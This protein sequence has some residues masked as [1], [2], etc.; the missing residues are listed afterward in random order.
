MLHYTQPLHCS[1]EAPGD[2]SHQAGQLLSRPVSLHTHA[3][4]TLLSIDM[5]TRAS[6][7]QVLARRI[8]SLLL[9]FEMMTRASRDQVLAR[10]I[11]ITLH[12]GYN[13]SQGHI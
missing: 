13:Q 4:I 5:T 9:S 7:D 1:I 2:G 8:P 3:A 12:A 10:R 11:S 6:R